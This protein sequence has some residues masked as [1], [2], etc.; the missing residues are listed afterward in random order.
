M[1]VFIAAVVAATLIV[2]TTLFNNVLFHI[3]DVQ[4]LGN[5]LV[6]PDPDPLVKFMNF[7]FREN[8]G[9]LLQS[10]RRWNTELRELLDLTRTVNEFNQDA[11]GVHGETLGLG[12]Q[13]TSN[14]AI[15][16]YDTYLRIPGFQGLHRSD[17]GYF[18]I[19]QPYMAIYSYPAIANPVAQHIQTIAQNSVRIRG[20]DRRLYAEVNDM[21]FTSIAPAHLQPDLSDADSQVIAT[22]SVTAN[23]LSRPVPIAHAEEVFRE[24]DMLLSNRLDEDNPFY[25]FNMVENLVRSFTHDVD[26]AMDIRSPILRSAGGHVTILDELVYLRRLLSRNG[27]P[28]EMVDKIEIALVILAVN[29][30][31]YLETGS[32]SNNTNHQWSSLGQFQTRTRRRFILPNEYDGV[33]INEA[34]NYHFSPLAL[35]TIPYVAGIGE[36]E[37]H[38][39]NGNVNDLQLNGS[40]VVHFYNLITGR[41][42]SG[43]AERYLS[44]SQ[45]ESLLFHNNRIRQIPGLSYHHIRLCRLSTPQAR[46]GVVRNF[47]ATIHESGDR[48]NLAGAVYAQMQLNTVPRDTYSHYKAYRWLTHYLLGY[49][50]GN[51]TFSRRF[52]RGYFVDHFT[53]HRLLGDTGFRGG[54]VSIL[55]PSGGLLRSAHNSMMNTVENGRGINPVP[56]FFGYIMFFR[57][58]ASNCLASMSLNQIRG[59]ARTFDFEILEGT[60]PRPE[61]IYT[62]VSPFMIGGTTVANGI[63]Q[64]ISF[65]GENPDWNLTAYNHITLMWWGFYRDSANPFY[66]HNADTRIWRVGGDFLRTRSANSPIRVIGI[67]TDTSRTFSDV[68]LTRFV[69]GLPPAEARTYFFYSEFPAEHVNLLRDVWGGQTLADFNRRAGDEDDA[70]GRVA[71]RQT[72]T[73]DFLAWLRSTGNAYY[74]QS[75]YSM[76]YTEFLAGSR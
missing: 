22:L 38:V 42:E 40:S 8:P 36:D 43:N 11:F 74:I 3:A 4:F 64:F 1:K 7:S 75:L 48:T 55:N 27:F 54:I 31:Q 47:F 58:I 72:P 44:I 14:A 2:A 49:Q 37:E 15:S 9:N 56:G 32:S 35:F 69:Y 13:D 51:I 20:H 45:I 60:V 5:T 24:F 6:S 17:S 39:W 16:R 19:W 30:R 57:Y 41:T 33:S 62:W 61:P 10:G 23:A 71:L 18:S 63:N 12:V 25:R 21:L 46:Y 67:H 52:D 29:D 73:P 66:G 65:M 59:E 28:S 26:R 53:T 70:H 68:F 76:S 34:L 50:A